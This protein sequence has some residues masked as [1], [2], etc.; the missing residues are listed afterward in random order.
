MR[1]ENHLIMTSGLVIILQLL[2]ERLANGLVLQ[3][4]YPAGLQPVE[5]LPR[6]LTRPGDNR[7]E[8]GLPRKSILGDSRE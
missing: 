5:H 8:I 7:I 2:V 1:A 3:V 4:D 6:V